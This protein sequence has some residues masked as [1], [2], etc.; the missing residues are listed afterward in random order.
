VSDITVESPS[1]SGRTREPL[2]SWSRTVTTF[3]VC[4][5][6][7]LSVIAAC[8]E[9]EESGEKTVAQRRKES[10]TLQDAD[11]RGKLRIAVW[12]HVPKISYYNPSTEEYE[13]F[14]IEIAKAMA[15][16][17]GFH[18][19]LVEW[20]SIGDLPDRRSILG[21]DQADMVVASFSMTKT[22]DDVAVAGPYLVVPQAVLV[23]KDRQKSLE[24]IPDLQAKNV[25]VCTA[26][27]ST[28]ATN[29]R[30]HGI[31][32]A[33]RDR[34]AQ[35][36]EGMRRGIYDAFSTDRHILA[37]YEW[38][39]EKKLG[40]DTFEVLD[41][42]IASA[43]EKLGIAVPEGDGAMRDLV[44]YFLHSWKEEAASPWLLAYDRT[45]GPLL[46]RAFR[47][48]PDVVDV[49]ELVDHDSRAPR[50]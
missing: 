45:I 18:T 5:L 17:L 1:W 30:K 6:V 10:E 50:A 4:C 13:G 29:L 20:V 15:D 31:R 38:A 23:R 7:A 35:C 14:D 16:D 33:L 9:N 40:S 11:R 34:N 26:T 3:F 44:A 36:M 24:T 12:K 46:P 2:N 25:V 43:D 49:P 41:T 37:V 19:G 27:G 47:S 8:S 32:L 48:Q 21:M 42:A 22:R 28:S 39:Y